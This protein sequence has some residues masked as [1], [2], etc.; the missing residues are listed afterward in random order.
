MSVALDIARTYRAPR[1]VIRHRAAPPVSEPRALAILMAGC[2][3]MFVAQW[4]ALSRAAWEDPSIP[5]DARLGGALLGWLIIAPLAFY[6][7]AAL[8]HGLALL[9]RGRASWYEARLALFWALLAASPLWLLTGLLAGFL[10]DG[11][12]FTLTGSLAGLAFL[13]FWGAGL[14]E[15]E[16]GNRLG[17]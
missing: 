3:M 16:A 7:L 5:L 8:S 4:P 11:P 14:F 15:T 9:F 17:A 10:G 6:G 1:R 13:F 2:L 12:A